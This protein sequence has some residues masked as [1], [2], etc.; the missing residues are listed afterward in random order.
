MPQMLDTNGRPHKYCPIRSYEIYI[1]HLHPE[2][3]ALW[4]Q[5][6]KKKP[7][8]PDQII[9]YKKERLGHNPLDSFMGKLSK[10]VGLSQHYT[11]HCIRVTGATNLYRKH[12]TPKQIMSVTGHKSI[13]SLAIYQCVKEDEKL[14]MG[15]SLTY[16]LLK[17]EEVQRILA[18]AAAKSNNNEENLAL[19]PP[20][21]KIPA[22]GL[23]QE[24]IPRNA[25]QAI[26]PPE[27]NSPQQC[28]LGAQ[29]NEVSSLQNALVPYKG[30]T[31]NAAEGHALPQEEDIDFN[32]AEM[33]SEF[34]QNTTDEQDMLLAAS[35]I[36]QQIAT[37]SHTCTTTT[38][39]KK[40]S[41]K[42]AGHV[43][44]TFQNCKIGH[45]GFINIHIHKH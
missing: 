45:I 39:I 1:G 8:D 27:M 33:L 12:Y 25:L 29:Q 36:E 24:A 38:M 19:E 2:I 37:T 17:P 14:M 10:K 4:Q 30:N 44:P 5:P 7:A 16:C 34:K 22:I 28:A 35:Q 40:N 15:M 23:P 42:V 20:P 43:N 13:E 32:L 11:N 31:S 26:A 3:D 9:W 41:P 6:L 18:A 21:N